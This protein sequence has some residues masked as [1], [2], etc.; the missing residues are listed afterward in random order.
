VG[1][2]RR[3]RGWFFYRERGGS[4]GRLIEPRADVAWLDDVPYRRKKKNS[5]REGEMVGF[6][7]E[8]G[9]EL[10]WA[11]REVRREAFLFSFSV[12]K[13]I[14]LFGLFFLDLKFK[15]IF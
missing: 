11:E 6:G 14:S 5:T 15:Y 7:S 4:S 3:G 12:F 9:Q 13:S 10:G 8:L 2:E 1:E